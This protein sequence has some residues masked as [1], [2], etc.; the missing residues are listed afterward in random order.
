VLNLYFCGNGINTAVDA[1]SMVMLTWL[2]AVLWTHLLE[3][4]CVLVLRWSIGACLGACLDRISE[5]RQSHYP[6]PS[7]QKQYN[8]EGTNDTTNIAIMV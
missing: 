2:V 5:Q 4:P 7:K 6:E 3:K 8:T 1:T